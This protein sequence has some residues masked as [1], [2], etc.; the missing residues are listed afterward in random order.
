M[1]V[2]ILLCLKFD[3]ETIND[4][5]IKRPW[6][7]VFKI[8]IQSIFDSYTN[9]GVFDIKT[10]EKLE[11]KAVSNNGVTFD[12]IETINIQ[13]EKINGK[14]QKINTYNVDGYSI[15]YRSGRYPFIEITT[16]QG[17]V[18]IVSRKN[19]KTEISLLPPVTP[20]EEVVTPVVETP[21]A[22]QEVT[23]VIE[24]K[25]EPNQ[26]PNT[27]EKANEEP[28]LEG[29]RDGGQQDQGRQESPELRPQEEAKEQVTIADF[30]AIEAKGQAGRKARQALSERVGKDVVA[31]MTRI[32]TKF[33]SI[34]T[35]LE[36]EGK[37]RKQCP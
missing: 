8:Q 35:S 27:D 30:S 24:A 11:S 7:D 29:L 28:L 17:D 14:E 4:Y 32:T 1:L 21:V 22:S 3:W 19:R 18:F 33:E 5:I 2:A 10:I 16:P 34:I 31:N 13:Y 12:P 23:P 20:M 26:K 37:I 25:N 9:R 36:K 6:Q 15:K